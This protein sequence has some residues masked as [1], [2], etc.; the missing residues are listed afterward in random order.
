MNRIVYRVL[1]AGLAAALMLGA[2]STPTPVPPVPT[3]TGNI[4]VNATLDGAQWSGRINYEVTGPF[5]DTEDNLPWSF[6]SVKAGVYSITYNYGGPAGAALANVSPAA[7]Q[8]LKAGGTIVFTLNFQ[9]PGD[10]RIGVSATLDGIPW[11]GGIDY[12]LY[13]PSGDRGSMVPTTNVSIPPGTYTLTY[14]SGGPSNAVF[15]GISPSAAQALAANGEIDYT[16]NFSSSAPASSLSVMAFYN[17]DYWTG[18]V[19]FS[20]SG[21]VSGSYSSVPL[22]L[23]DVPDGTYRI[24]YRSGGPSGGS[25]GGITP[26]TTLVVSGGRSAQFTMTFYTQS[27]SGNVVV[28]AT[29]DGSPWSGSANYSL[30]NLAYDYTVP[31]TYSSVPV[32]GY[33]LTYL[34]GGP[35]NASLSSITP[36]PTQSLYAGRTIIFT[37]NFTSQQDTGNITVFAMVD[38]KQWQ[39]NP[40]AG[41][42]SYSITSTGLADTEEAIPGYLNGFPSGS[43]TLLYNSGGP[44]GA[45]LTGISPSPT[46]YLPAGGSIVYTLNFT[47]LSRG[48]VVVNATLNGMSWYGVAD[49]VVNGPYVQ[50]GD[51]VSRTFDDAPQ[52]TYSVTFRDGGPWNAQFVGVSPSSQ[53]LQPGG[54]ITFTLVFRN[55]PGPGPMPGPVPNPTPGPMPGPVPNPTPEPMPGPVPNPTPEPMPGPLDQDLS[56]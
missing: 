53:E 43:Y 5:T 21:P 41:P 8:Q 51:Q 16:L 24:T 34:S 45:T 38:G 40:G 27:Q 36:V 22:K 23:P 50:S 39:T 11:Q 28:Q 49:Y 44:V 10:T 52:G 55:L 17:G 9:T 12:S 32:G 15:N 3:P 19:N 2:C 26:D 25:L 20:I 14:N 33:T 6:N 37:L 35:S 29:L 31:R 54:Y 48:Y 30:S 1:L 4:F 7:A 13:G 42:I 56:P 46:Q 47:A 18:P